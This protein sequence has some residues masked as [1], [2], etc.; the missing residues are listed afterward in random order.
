[1]R[2]GLRRDLLVGAEDVGVVLHEAAHAQHAV[3]RA[4]RLVAVAR[5]ELGHADRQVAVALQAL[6]ENLHMRRGSSSA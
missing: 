5:A 3:Q 6:L 2:G 1:M 4:G